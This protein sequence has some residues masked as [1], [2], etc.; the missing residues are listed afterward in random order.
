MRLNKL[1]LTSAIAVVSATLFSSCL[2]DQEDIFPESS[3]ERLQA[4]LDKCKEVLTSSEYGWAFDY[5]PDRHQTLGGY[6]YTCKFVGNEVTAGFEL[7][8]GVSETSY[9]KLTNDNGPVLSFDTYNSLLHYFATPSSGNYEALDGD[10]EFMIMDVQDDVIKLRGKRNCNYAYLHRL[11]KDAES[12]LAEVA[13]AGDNIFHKELIG[14]IGETPVTIEMQPG[15]GSRYF[16]AQWGEDE[17]FGSTFVPTPTG[18]RFMDPITVNGVSV[19]ELNYKVTEFVYVG[20]DSKGNEVAL[21]GERPQDYSEYD[22]YVGEFTMR[23][24][25]NGTKSVN[26]TIVAAGD[27]KYTIKGLGNEFDVVATYNEARGCMQFTSQQVGV[28]GDNYY[29][30]CAVGNDPDTGKAK[31]SWST[32]CGFLAKKDPA[33]PGTFL[34]SP[35]DYNQ[36]RAHSLMVWRFAGSVDENGY[37]NGGQAANPW[38]LSTK[39]A[40]MANLYSFVKK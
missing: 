28:D 36:M 5:Y 8:P 4:T 16:E 22:E 33:N 19:A 3:A 30:L 40:Q 18:I 21:Q 6:V 1:F 17:A 15:R 39:S 7:Q 26:V 37:A 27:H 9:Y 14:S 38:R 13:A 25:N 10:F 2:K 34:I 31:P 20:V 12:Y 35:N 32:D 11:D 24:S 23:Y 29:W